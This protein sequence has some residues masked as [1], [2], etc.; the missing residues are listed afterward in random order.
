MP[1]R[2]QPI[3]NECRDVGLHPLDGSI[4]E[5]HMWYIVTQELMTFPETVGKQ[6]MVVLFQDIIPQIAHDLN[7]FP[8]D[9]VSA[10]INIISEHRAGDLGC[11]IF[12][13]AL[14]ETLEGYR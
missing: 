8:S 2:P 14:V 1:I 3:D 7:G 5:M 9:K 13:R 6:N 11:Q 12:M 10:L 4:V